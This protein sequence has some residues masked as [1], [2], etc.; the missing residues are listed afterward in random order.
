MLAWHAANIMNCWTKRR[1]KVE[2]LMRT[3]KAPQFMRGGG[4]S[5]AARFD[6]HMRRRKAEAS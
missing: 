4:A 1:V 2:H 5:E 6:E 3:K